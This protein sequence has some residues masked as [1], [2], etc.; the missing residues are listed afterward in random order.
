MEEFYLTSKGR[1]QLRCCLWRPE[2]EPRAIVQIVHGIAEHVERYGDFA[3]YLTQRGILVTAEDHMG[4]GKS[5]QEGQPKGRFYGGWEAAVADSNQLRRKVQKEY[6]GVP[7]ILF[8][9]SMGSFMARTMLYRYPKAGL[10]GAV[11]CGT[12]WMPEPVLKAGLAA[13]ELSVRRHGEDYVDEGMRGLIFGGY[14]A[15]IE[16][17]RTPYDWICT[18]P[19]LVD[20]YAADPMCGFSETVSLDRDML[21]GILQIQKKQNLA[22]MPKGLPVLLIAG[23]QDPVGSYG[24]GVAQCLSAFAKA[25]M[26]D[27]SMKLYPEGRHEILNEPWREQVY[28]DIFSWIVEKI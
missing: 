4:H 19:E 24:K 7:Y 18:D 14:N 1:G 5:W 9:H 17:V 15:K 22:A 12:G 25:G 20:R 3:Y 2:G 26:E 6:P 28:H 8:G 16:N 23:S 10:A 21:G 13:C 11:L 27:V